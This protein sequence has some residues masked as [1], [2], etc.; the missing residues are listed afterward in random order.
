MDQGVRAL[1]HGMTDSQPP[2]PPPPCSTLARPRHR[3]AGCRHS[4][5]NRCKCGNPFGILISLRLAARAFRFLAVARRPAPARARHLP[6]RRPADTELRRQYRWRD[7]HGRV[8][9]E[10]QSRRPAARRHAAANV[11]RA[12]NP[13]CFPRRGAPCAQGTQ[14]PSRH[15]RTRHGPWVSSSRM[16]SDEVAAIHRGTM[17]Q[18]GRGAI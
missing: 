1:D 2:T 3:R 17:L 8:R 7:G 5:V 15:M 4:A 9:F 18:R 14:T 11:R 10:Y 16:G 12:S 13:S 6:W